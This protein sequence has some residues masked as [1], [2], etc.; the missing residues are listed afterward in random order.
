MTSAIRCSGP[1][2]ACVGGPL[3]AGCAA[4]IAAGCDGRVAVDWVDEIALVVSLCANVAVQ[5]KLARAAARLTD[6]RKEFK[7]DTVSSAENSQLRRTLG[8]VQLVV[9]DVG[10]VSHF[11][12]RSLLNAREYSPGPA[13]GSQKGRAGKRRLRE[14]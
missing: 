6:N 1:C 11:W 8:Q 12:V 4:L 13:T 2:G 14:E 3:A 5:A 10:H 7:R 9:R